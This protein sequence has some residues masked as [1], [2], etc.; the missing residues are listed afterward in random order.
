MSAPSGFAG[1]LPLGAFAAPALDNAR[2][3]SDAFA[4][5]S[6]AVYGYVIAIVHDPD[7]A[8]DVTQEAFLRLFCELE[9]GR[10]V[11]E[12]RAWLFRVAHNLALN[13][14]RDAKKLVRIDDGLAHSIES[15]DAPVQR[16]LEERERRERVLAA[17]AGLSSQERRSIELRARGLRY[18]E[19]AG[20][21]D[22]RI[23]SVSNYVERAIAKIARA[24]ES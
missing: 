5:W 11:R 24:L 10:A 20:I 7:D 17:L 16:K 19:I 6:G 1:E 18:K 2:L 9:Q 12:P 15:P 22:V 3:V 21:L 23:S 8:E 14:R 13:W 4:N